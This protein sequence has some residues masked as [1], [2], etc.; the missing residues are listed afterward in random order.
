MSDRALRIGLIVSIILNV[1]LVGGVVGGLAFW[2][3]NPQV[4]ASAAPAN[5]PQQRRALRFAADQLSTQQQRAFRQALRQARMD[6]LPNLR[7]SQAQ[8]RELVG[9]IGA[10]TFDRSAVMS[11]LS[12]ARS[13][14]AAVR[15]RL[16]TAIVDYA[17]GL[18]P[19]DRAVFVQGLARS[20][21]LRQPPARRN[22]Q[23]R[24][25]ENPAPAR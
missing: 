4:H 22:L 16:E 15:A 17:A 21:T 23:D 3:L 10:E 13:A 19:A 8:R 25:T 1:F 11:A 24:A 18:S 2:R 7:E 12:R 14:D 6:T 9:L 5:A 20:P